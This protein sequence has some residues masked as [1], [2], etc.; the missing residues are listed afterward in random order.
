VA[1]AIYGGS[2]EKEIL[3]HLRAEGGTLTTADLAAYRVIAAAGARA[4]PRRRVRSNPP[5]SSGG[6]LIGYGLRLLDALGQRRCRQRR[7]DR[8]AG[9]GMRERGC[10]RAAGLRPLWGGLAARPYLADNVRA[11]E[12]NS[13]D[14]RGVP[15]RQRG[16]TQISVVD[17]HGNAASMTASPARARA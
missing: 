4:L 12:A 9:R 6:V 11:A 1:A 10:A 16:T 3:R 15:D 2:L 14:W 8:S 5:P 7:C 13:P 17:A